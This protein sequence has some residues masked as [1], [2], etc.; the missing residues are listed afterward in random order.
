MINLGLFGQDDYY[1]TRQGDSVKC[2]IKK[3]FPD[4]IKVKTVKKDDV[5]FEVNEIKGF[6]KDGIYFVSKEITNRDRNPFIF[7]PDNAG[8]IKYNYDKKFKPG[9]W[10]WVKADVAV[11]SGR[12][13]RIY[14]L[15]ET[16][17]P[18]KIMEPELRI[19]FISKM[20]RWD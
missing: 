18:K 1:I 17:T 9:Q 13:I 12:G 20:I 10:D 8:D 4:G 5:S 15:I 3:V 14:E 2:E 11:T 19:R 7:L 6:K 16:G